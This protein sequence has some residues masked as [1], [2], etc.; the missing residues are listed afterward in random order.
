MLLLFTDRETATLSPVA[1]GPGCTKSALSDPTDPPARTS[2]RSVDPAG[3]EM[4]LVPFVPKKPITSVLSLEVV[5][6]GARSAS[7]LGEYRPLTLSTGSPVST[8]P[9][10]WIAPAAARVRSPLHIEVDGRGGNQLHV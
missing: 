9:S 3:G 1:P 6:E 2:W 7:V 4:P 10:R 5:M 8:P